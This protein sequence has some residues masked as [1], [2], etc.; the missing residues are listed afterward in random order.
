MVSI[1]F[2][3]GLE[4]LQILFEKCLKRHAS[5]TS[6]FNNSMANKKKDFFD[7][8]VR[9]HAMLFMSGTRMAQIAASMKAVNLAT[10]GR[11][12]GSSSSSVIGN[13]T[14]SYSYSI[15]TQTAISLTDSPNKSGLSADIE[16]EQLL[17]L[18]PIVL[19]EF[20]TLF[21]HLL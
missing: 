4:N 15:S 20:D 6:A 1:P 14:N 13:N 3:G 11:S 19:E 7:M 18:F 2:A 16:Y 12:R 8:F 9:T 17:A 21:D 10:S 5:N